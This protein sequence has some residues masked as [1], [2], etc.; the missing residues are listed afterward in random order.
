MAKNTSI[1]LGDHFESFIQKLLG[2]GR[3]GSA[4]EVVRRIE[5]SGREG[6]QTAGAAPRAY[7]G[8]KA[9]LPLNSISMIS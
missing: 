9:V 3:Y 2:N 7:S 8:K 6:S 1:A 4:S 5:A